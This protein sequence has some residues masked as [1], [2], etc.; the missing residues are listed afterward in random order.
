[1]KA[2]LILTYTLVSRVHSLQ[3]NI[4]NLCKVNTRTNMLFREF[5]IKGHKNKRVN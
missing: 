2:G 5:S 1:M 4:Y 3:I